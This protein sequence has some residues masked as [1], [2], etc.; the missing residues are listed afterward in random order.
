MLSIIICV[1]N[2]MQY[3]N[4]M[5]YCLNKISDYNIKFIIIDDKSSDES[6]KIIHY[7]K[8]KIQNIFVYENSEKLGLGISRNIGV[9]LANTK[10]ITFMDCDDYVYKSGLK[11]SL[12]SI[13]KQNADICLSPIVKKLKNNSIQIYNIDNKPLTNENSFKM[14]IKREF[15][16]WSAASKIYKTKLIKENNIKFKE[17]VLYE[18]VVFGMNAHISATKTIITNNP[19]YVYI[20][21]D[22]SITRRTNYSLLHVYSSLILHNDIVNF[23]RTN[24]YAKNM[25]H[26]MLAALNI[27]EKEHYPRVKQGYLECGIAHNETYK[28][29]YF[30][31]LKGNHTNFSAKCLQLALI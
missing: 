17:S 30:D 1:H 27:L 7:Y 6:N 2:G 12:S 31:L 9:S 21:N 16:T 26:E 25:P 3:L 11:E 4:K 20:Q 14:Y 23:F 13:V 22:N 8:N 19:Y 5:F 28:S 10:Y 24:E 18:D 15:T 29:Q